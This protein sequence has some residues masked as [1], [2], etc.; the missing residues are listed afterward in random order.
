MNSE[1]PPQLT[2]HHALD[3]LKALKLSPDGKGFVGYGEEHNWTHVPGL[4][5]LPYF[6]KLLLPHNIDVMH[7]EKNVAEAIFST[8][9]DIPE[10]TK[11][12]VNAR[13]DQQTLCNRPALNMHLNVT[14]DKWEKPRASYC[15]NRAQKR[16]ILEW[17][18]EIKFHDG[19]AANL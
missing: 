5:Q 19:Y 8:I 6:H 10:K 11:D 13:V 14:I 17:F 4:W 1:S 2:G 18:Q 3:Q 15:L 7:N 16:E 12:N 9:F